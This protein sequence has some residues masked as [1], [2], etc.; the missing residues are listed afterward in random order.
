[1]GSTNSCNE[2]LC[3]MDQELWETGK[4]MLKLKLT[5]EMIMVLKREDC[6]TQQLA[7]LHQTGGLPGGNLPVWI[8]LSI[9]FISTGRRLVIRPSGLW[10]APIKPPRNHHPQ[11]QSF[12]KEIVARRHQKD[13]DLCMY[14]S[15]NHQ[16]APKR[17]TTPNQSCSKDKSVIQQLSC[18]KIIIIISRRNLLIRFM[19]CLV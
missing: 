18:K 1:M 8:S 13:Q 17:K 3:M 15:I 11:I 14:L 16:T 7:T 19:F 2:R 10:V 9:S 12:F 4:E 6:R 5:C